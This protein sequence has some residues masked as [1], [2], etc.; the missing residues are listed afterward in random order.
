MAVAEKDFSS[1]VTTAEEV[2]IQG[3]ITIH[4]LILFNTTAATA[5]IQMF[6]GP[7]SQ[8]VLGTTEPHKVIPLPASSGVAVNVGDGWFLGGTG[9]TI[10]A[11][12]TRTGSSTAAVDVLMTF[13]PGALI[14]RSDSVTT[15]Q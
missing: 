10:A 2:W 7:T 12:T 15:N 8:F 5:Y 4:T 13:N 1:Q 14:K 6:V 3:P 9:L 11:T